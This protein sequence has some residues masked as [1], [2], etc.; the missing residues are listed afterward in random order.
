MVI[1]GDQRNRGGQV[2]PGAD[3]RGGQTALRNEHTA[4]RRDQHNEQAQY[5]VHDRYGGTAE[6][7][8]VAIIAGEECR[9]AQTNGCQRQC[10]N[11]PESNAREHPCLVH[12]R[13]L[14]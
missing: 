3:A 5:P 6:I 11:R 13:Y 12:D 7:P 10:R 8:D 1:G 9:S 14:P 2:T 4:H